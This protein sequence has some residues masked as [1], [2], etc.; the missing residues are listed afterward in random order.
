MSKKQEWFTQIIS[1]WK[2][3]KKLL[4]EKA[5]INPYTFKM[6]LAG[7]PNYHFTEEERERIAQVLRNLATDI[8]RLKNNR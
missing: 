1:D 8:A 7:K 4:A 3:N 5:E 2:L 6:K